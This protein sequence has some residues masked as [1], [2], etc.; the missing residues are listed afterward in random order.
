MSA[1]APY[2]GQ[3]PVATDCVIS[4]TPDRQQLQRLIL[5]T[6]VDEKSLE[7]EFRLPFVTMAIKNTFSNNFFIYVCR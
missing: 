2:L 6:N 3:L 1:I 5:S 7:I 4:D